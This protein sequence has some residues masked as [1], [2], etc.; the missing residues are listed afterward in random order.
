[1]AAIDFDTSRINAFS[2]EDFETASIRSAAPSYISEA[3]SYHTT[4]STTETIPPYSP[5]Q[6]GNTNTNGNGTPASRSLL[7]SHTAHI[8]SPGL[9]PIPPVRSSSADL[10]SL[11]AFR[12]PSWSVN[13]NPMY[14]RVATRRAQAAMSSGEGLVRNAARVLE[15]VNEEGSS[16]SGSVTPA[17]SSSSRVRPLE[18]PYLVG[19]V[20]AAR[21]RRERLARENTE[22]ILHRE[23]RRWDWF[24][25]ELL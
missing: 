1:M 16:G 8:P 10:P 2:A 24:L 4:V 11:G 23:D 13:T 17:D 7:P 9:P 19:E 21:A 18:D 20:A 15:R 14:Q 25:G 22:D 5:P 12:I 3:P 6:S